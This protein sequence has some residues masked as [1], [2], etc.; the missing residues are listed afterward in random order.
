MTNKIIKDLKEKFAA[1]Y[2]NNNDSEMHGYFSPGRVNLI[3]EHIDYNGGYVF[4]CALDFGTYAVARKNGTKTIN[5]ATEN[6]PTTVSV[7]VNGITYKEEDDWT[8]YPKGVIKAFQEKGHTIGGFDVLYYG[9][10]PNGS[11]LSSSAS[12][13]V[14]TA[15]VVN[16]LFECGENMVDMVKMSQHAENNFVGVNCGIMDQFAV[17]MGQ[18]DHAI[19]LDCETL[20]YTQVPMVL[21]GVKI[22]IG[23]TKKRRGLADSKY[24]ERRSECDAALSDLQKSLDINALCAMDPDT[25]EKNK[26]L[27]EN[28][29]NRN[30]AEHAVYENAR[31]IQATKALEAGDVATFG[32]L[33]NESH[34]SLRDLYEVTGDELDAMVEEAWRVEGVMG[35]RMTGA[36]FGGCTVSLVKEEA[37]E[38]FIQQVGEKYE[39]RTG[40]KPEFY[41]ANVG[42]GAG[43]V[44][45][46]V[47][48]CGGAG[49][50]GSHTVAALIEQGRDVIVFDN[51]YKGHRKAVPSSVK[52]YEG[53][54]RN[55]EELEKVFSENNITAVI[56]FAADSLVGES[57]TQPLKYYNNNVYGTLC[58]LEKM[59]EHDVKHIVFSSTAATYG[60]PE[61][62]PIKESDRT[63]PTNPYGETKLAV[64]KMLKWT[65]N[66]HGLTYSVLRYFNAA[67]AHKDGSI[68]EDH[69]P[70]SHLVP[71]ILQ[72]ANG[73]REKIMIFG[74]DYP[75]AD[76]TCIRDY[77]H[78][79]DL[80]DAHIL[81]LDRLMTGASSKT[82][83]LGNGQ[84]F[85]VKEIIGIAR[86]VTGHPIPAEVAPRRAG[87]PAVLIASADE[88]IKELGWRPRFN[89]IEQIIASAWA[90]H[91]NNPDGYGED[92]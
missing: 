60:E 54:L 9:L 37:V 72:V 56:D 31:T 83:N 42:Q 75:T 62:V 78:V 76:G 8:N 14:L 36:G 7:D 32:K 2:P 23:N 51:L 5:F 41:V 3:G 66:A 67:G 68:G 44:D 71:I 48:V 22:V 17:G 50:I 70:E 39:A 49:Y 16:D 74:D 11:G 43:R 81:A 29:V 19:L 57:V 18:K 53:D 10:I 55:K 91:K 20:D 64:E 13:E 1:R 28:P 24:N 79:T 26:G 12:L 15:V 58:L 21:E 45:G 27:I 40:L 47:L 30:R 77:I 35:S 69:S 46:S 33:M 86:S 25:F 6:F 92:K 88:A 65:D 38:S 61:S 63:E 34:I 4:P 84:G 87:D 80:A 59:V 89:T 73:Q 82:F 52:F 90:W 85:S